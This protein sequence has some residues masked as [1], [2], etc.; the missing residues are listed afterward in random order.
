MDN[1]LTEK[2]ELDHYVPK[3][4]IGDV[5]LVTQ[6]NKNKYNTHAKG[7]ITKIIYY[8]IYDYLLDDVYLVNEYCVKHTEEYCNM[9]FMGKTLQYK[10][11]ELIF[12]PISYRNKKIDYILEN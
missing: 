5:V 9:F 4:K 8:S 1:H 12:E 11:Y 6:L 7:I 10:E 3:F 2:I